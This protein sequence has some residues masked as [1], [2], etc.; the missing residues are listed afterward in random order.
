MFANFFCARSDYDSQNGLMGLIWAANKGHADCVRLLIDAGADKEA[1]SEV[2][3]RSLH[4]FHLCLLLYF[5][6]FD[7]CPLSLCSISFLLIFTI[8]IYNCSTHFPDHFLYICWWR[9]CVGGGESDSQGGWTALSIAA[10]RGRTDCARLL[11]DAGANKE[12]KINVRVG[13][14]FPGIAF[15]VSSSF[16]PMFHVYCFLLL[17]KFLFV[18]IFDFL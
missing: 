14:C 5:L 2:S 10:A 13:R 4:I 9:R 12:A 16:L 18:L 3:A 8:K 6:R 7:L 17:F 15:R 1:K 11:L